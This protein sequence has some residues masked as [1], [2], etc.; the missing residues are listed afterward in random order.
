MPQCVYTV[1]RL[2]RDLLLFDVSV[3]TKKITVRPYVL[4]HFTN[5]KVTSTHN[6]QKTISFLKLICFQQC[7]QDKFVLISST[8]KKSDGH[9]SNRVLFSVFIVSLKT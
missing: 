8:S 6:V 3:L 9:I 5:I 4:D 7:F 1:S 2:L